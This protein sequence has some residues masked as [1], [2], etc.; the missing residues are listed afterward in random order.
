MYPLLAHNVPVPFVIGIYGHTGITQHGLRP[1]GGHH[2][3]PSLLPLN[4]IAK[5][6]KAARLILILHLYIGEGGDTVRAPVD[7]AGAFV[8]KPL[9]VKADKDMADSFGKA[10]IHGEACPV[11]IAGDAHLLLLLHNAAAILLLPVPYPLQKLFPPQVIA[12]QALILPQVFF[13]LGLGCNAGMVTAGNPQGRIP[14]HPLEADQNIL[15]RTVHGVTH[16]E[17]P[18]DVRRGHGNGEGLLVRVPVCL[19][20]SGS[21]PHFI[22]AAFYLLGFIGLG[23]FFAHIKTL[24]C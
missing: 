18:G 19:K 22:N 9:I 10:L 21:L 7:N 17:L 11:P 2:Q 4:G 6:P 24:L 3:I 1:S 8:N 5:M 15:Q 13:H 14:L 20:A 12:G 23:Q 16:V